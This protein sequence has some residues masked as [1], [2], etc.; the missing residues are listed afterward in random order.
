MAVAVH[1][2]AVAARQRDEGLPQVIILLVLAEAPV[3]PVLAQP[4]RLEI[5]M[6][7]GSLFR[8]LP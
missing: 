3:V 7:V 6:G 4:S 1:L 8:S 5:L 2:L